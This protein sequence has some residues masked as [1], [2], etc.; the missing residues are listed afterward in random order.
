MNPIFANIREG[1]KRISIKC[2]TGEQICDAKMG[3]SSRVRNKPTT[4]TYV[5]KD[6]EHYEYLW[7][8]LTFIMT[9]CLFWRS[10]IFILFIF[11][12][13]HAVWFL[14]LIIRVQWRS[15][16]QTGTRTTQQPWKTQ[17]QKG[18]FPS[19]S[20]ITSK[21]HQ[22]QYYKIKEA[23]AGDRSHDPWRL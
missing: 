3:K 4:G 8:N 2:E 11:Y 14:K 17:Q 9:L 13:N 18:I 22:S 1:T 16:S 19:Q 20:W 12:E 21:T 10:Y 15:T 6:N 5:L 23:K 7:L